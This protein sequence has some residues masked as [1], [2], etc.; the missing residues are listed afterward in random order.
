MRLVNPSSQTVTLR[1]VSV[2]LVIGLAGHGLR[3]RFLAV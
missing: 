3:R 1:L 2:I